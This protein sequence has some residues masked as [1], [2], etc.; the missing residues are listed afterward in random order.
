[1]FGIESLTRAVD[2]NTA[3]VDRHTTALYALGEL[4]ERMIGP[5]SP[6]GQFRLNQMGKDSGMLVYNADLPQLPA[7]HPQAADTV[8]GRIRLFYDDV[9]QPAI[10]TPLGA[11]VHEGIRIPEGTRVRGQFAFVD[12]SGNESTNPTVLTEFT[13]SDTIPPPDAEGGFGLTAVAEEA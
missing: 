11:T 5:P 9:E 7:D 13:A 1:M 12:N 2:R 3:A 4:L 6:A 8:S 10:D